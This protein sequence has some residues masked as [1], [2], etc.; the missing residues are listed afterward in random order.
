MMFFSILFP[1][2]QAFLKPRGT[3]IPEYFKDLR[4]DQIIEPLLSGR[5]AYGLEGFFLTPLQETETL[6]YRQEV[7]REL[8]NTNIRWWIRSFSQDVSALGL[9]MDKMRENLSSG[10][11]W[12]DNYLT[13]GRML[14]AAERYIRSVD[15]LFGFLVKWNPSSKGLSTFVGYFRHY[16]NDESYKS[17]H[18]ATIDVRRA[19]SCLRYCMLMKNGTIKVRA[20]DGEEDLSSQVEK[21]FMKFRQGKMKDYRQEM[22][23]DPYADHV[24]A[25]VLALL[26]KTFPDAFAALDAYC[27]RFSHFDDETL[28]RF[29]R[30]IQF[31]LVW[32]DMTDNLREQGLPFCYPEVS[33]EGKDLHAHQFFDLALALKTKHIVPN[34]FL[35]EGPE[36]VIVVTGPNQGGKTTFARAFGQLHYLASLGFCVP[37]TDDRLLLCDQILTHFGREEDL[38][39][40]NGNLQDDLLRLHALLDV[41][42]E[43]SI[44]IVNEIFAS[45]TAHDALA[46]GK[47]MMDA[48]VTLGSPAVV[49]TFLD[50]LAT[51]GPKVVSMMSTVSPEAPDKRTFKIVR[52][53][54]DGLAY[55]LSLA[56]MH[57]LTY[58]QLKRRLEG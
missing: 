6:S 37:G 12:Y 52:K 50:E 14:D 32:L 57:G 54:P 45:T 34:D 48:I 44:I 51:M 36:Q 33:M 16:F 23:D 56:K 49:V 26:A 55:A 10:E 4:L 43:R 21:T 19:F 29:S 46:L 9:E 2:E 11:S 1:T 3:A 20:Y 41:A 24:E 15:T 30:E 58:G 7:M 22:S 5:K 25:G 8:E 39:E 38:S 47:R 31:Y 42:T 53:P 18:Q 27:T 13:R 17:F 35:L 40:L 28:L